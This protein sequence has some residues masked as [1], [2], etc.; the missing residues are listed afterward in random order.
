MRNPSLEETVRGLLSE[1]KYDPIKQ[2]EKEKK[3]TIDIGG[4]PHDPSGPN[5]AHIEEDEQLDEISGTATSFGGRHNPRRST[6]KYLAGRRLKTRASLQASGNQRRRPGVYEEI[7]EKFMK[8][9]SEK[10]SEKALGKTATGQPGETIDTE[11]TNQ[12]L[13]GPTR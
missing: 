12:E 6:A 10:K 9:L 1:Q 5:K 11:P 3:P 4:H 13:T 7:K 8:K 2:W